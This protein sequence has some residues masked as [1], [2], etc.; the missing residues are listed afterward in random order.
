[1][2][3]AKRI[4]VTPNRNEKLLQPFLEK[5]PFPKTLV[6]RTFLNEASIPVSNFPKMIQ[7]Q[8]KMLCL[9]KHTNE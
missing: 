2:E 3:F 5:Q 7:I 9:N 4:V 1:M 6:S 8:Q